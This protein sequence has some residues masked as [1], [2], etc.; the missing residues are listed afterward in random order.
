M[1]NFCWNYNSICVI[2]IFINFL[3]FIISLLLRVRHT[4]ISHIQIIHVQSSKST[5]RIITTDRF[6]LILKQIYSL[7]NL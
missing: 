3:Q 4:R 7:Q 2:I 5:N 6:L 1:K